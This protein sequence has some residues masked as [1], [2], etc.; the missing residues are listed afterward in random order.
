MTILWTSARATSRPPTLHTSYR[1]TFQLWRG[2]EWAWVLAGITV[3]ALWPFIVNAFWL[4]LSNLALV[5][6]VATV[7][8]NMLSGNARL[9]SLGQA[10]FLAVGGFAAGILGAQH[11][12]P[13]W[14]CLLTAAVAG[15]LV[16]VVVG[17]PSLR[18]KAIYIAITTLGLHFA[19]TTLVSIYQT[20]AVRAHGIVMPI[21]DLGFVK[22]GDLRPWFYFLLLV[23][24][25][26]IV[27]ALNIRRSYLGRRWIAVAD[28][29][30]AAR[31]A[32]INIAGAKL[33][34]FAISSALVSLA[35]ALGAYYEG[36]LT[37][38]TYDIQLAIAYLAMIIVGGVG[39]VLGSVLGA[40]SLTFLPYLLDFAMT[41]AGIA[42]SGGSLNGIH[43]IA[44]GAL[45]LV[46]LL[47]EP[48]GLAAIWYR[49]RNAGM[50]WPLKYTSLE[51]K[52]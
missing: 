46:F 6:V 16:G 26:V 33:S 21:P 36:V 25:V 29:E 2:M 13:F 9:V 20:E 15:A 47:F 45:I 35:G 30:V 28:H 32:G 24:V 10:A 3:V 12:F 52:R 40:V 44:Y 39:S 19:V 23:T 7:G 49:I 38:E 1:Q 8:L 11:G 27:V 31:S 50:L 37:A 51:S 41:A 48:L 17:V 14:V 43:S 42:L 5:A 4:H 34:A 22:L 18:L